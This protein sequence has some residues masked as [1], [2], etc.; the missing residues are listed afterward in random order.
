[1][2]STAAIARKVAGDDAAERPRL[3]GI[4]R[5]FGPT[6][7]ATHRL[8]P[9][10]R[11]VLNAII[12]C[13]TAALGGHLFV[14]DRCELTVPVYN[15]CRNRSCPTCQALD[16][17]RWIAART[18]RLLPV[19]HHHVV[20][21]LPA[22]LRP[23]ARQHPRQV[24]GALF[25]AAAQT[26]SL[27]AREV[28]GV[29]IG[30]TA[31]LHTWTRRLDFHPHLHCVVTAGGLAI[32]G[33]RWVERTQYLFHVTRMKAVFRG[34]LLASLQRRHLSGDL[35]L[36]GDEPGRPS[37]EAWQRWTKTLPPC[38]KWVVYIEPPFG[39]S[40]HVLQY[41][42][43]YTHRIGISDA[44]LVSYDAAGVTF[45]THGDDTATLSPNLFIARFLQHVLPAGFHKIR[46]FGLY[47]SANVYRLWPKAAALL[48]G[49]DGLDEHAAKQ[50]A[51]VIA[52]ADAV[53]LLGLLTGTDV[54]RCTRCEFGHMQP[55][56]LPRRLEKPP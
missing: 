56:A 51:E 1:M 40:T 13:R 47:A 5:Q 34:R 31:V 39:R 7:L 33:E 8:P 27:L 43:R 41:L 6:Y 52:A 22:E 19:G 24:Y 30:V 11:R 3:A 36:D 54:L 38:R 17:A 14:C 2:L 20:F 15:S 44:R 28:L 48:G 49:G 26:L 45:R 25:E 35:Q 16:Q 10:Q 55:K 9:E 21:T 50:E 18:Q 29:R 53:T 42:G 4:F 32:D 46:H 12:K 37:E 23:L